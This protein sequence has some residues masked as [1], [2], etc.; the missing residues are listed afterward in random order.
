MKNTWS[1]M[2]EITSKMHQHSKSKLPHK[3]I[4]I[5]I[6]KHFNEYFTKIDPSLARKFLSQATL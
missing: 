3:P 6:A 5:E 1:V 4:G 2:K